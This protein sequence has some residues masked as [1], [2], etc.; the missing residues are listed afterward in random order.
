MAATAAP[1]SPA[2][3][4]TTP[5]ETAVF[6]R[7]RIGNSSDTPHIHKLLY[8]LAAYQ[9]VTHLFSATESSIAAT[10]FNYPPFQSFTVFLLEVSPTPFPDEP[11]GIGRMII[12]LDIPI[13]DPEWHEFRSAGGGGGGEAVVVGLTL[14]FPNY[15][16]FLGKPGFHIEGLYVRES[17]RKKGFGKMLLSAVA[18]QAVKMGYAKVDWHVLD[19]NMNA[20]GFYE[21]MG[22]EILHQLKICR[23]SPT[24]LQAYA[25]MS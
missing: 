7:I 22:A 20:I 1:P 5:P 24:A 6:T 21:K 12:N 16:M 3:P 25:N 13:I 19:W 2:F 14:F 18:A 17:Y 11:V 23:L 4:T 9:R 10:L 8:Q 15:G